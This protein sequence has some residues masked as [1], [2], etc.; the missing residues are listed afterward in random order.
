MKLVKRII[1][2]IIGH[3]DVSVALDDLMVEYGFKY[4]RVD[5]VGCKRCRRYPVCRPLH[6]PASP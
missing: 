6:G 5:A 4:T 1:C 2:A 3:E